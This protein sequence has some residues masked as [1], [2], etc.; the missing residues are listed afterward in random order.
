MYFFLGGSLGLLESSALGTWYLEL[1][2]S[3]QQHGHPVLEEQ[4]RGSLNVFL[5]VSRVLIHA[6]L[7][8]LD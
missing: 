3:H 2:R 6:E 4:R 8:A 7:T 5:Q 1:V